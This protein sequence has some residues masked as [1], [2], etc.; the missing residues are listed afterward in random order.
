MENVFARGLCSGMGVEAKRIWISLPSVIAVTGS[1]A[2]LYLVSLVFGW[3]ASV[4]FGLL[5]ASLMATVWMVIRIL[6][7][8]YTTEKTFDRYFYLDRPD[9]SRNGDE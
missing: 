4:I 8:P 9:L 6:K 2:V 5:S 3:P 7:D 1:I